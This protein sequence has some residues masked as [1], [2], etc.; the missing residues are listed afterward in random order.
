MMALLPE[1][2]LVGHFRVM[3]LDPGAL[4]GRDRLRQRQLNQL[5]A[6]LRMH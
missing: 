3:R 1:C 4:Y 5:P 2:H 6:E